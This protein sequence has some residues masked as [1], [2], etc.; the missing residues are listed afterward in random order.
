M[1]DIVWPPVLARALGVGVRPRNPDI[2]AETQRLFEEL[3]VPLLRFLSGIGVRAADGE[4]ILQEAF[5]AL[6][7]H[8]QE[9]RPRDNL[10]AWLYRVVHNLGLRHLQRRAVP[11]GDNLNEL[12]AQENWNPEA[13]T[14]WQQKAEILQGLI[15]ALPQTDRDILL[16][17]GQGLR[18]REI[19]EALEISLGTVAQSIARSLARLTRVLG[20][21]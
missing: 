11:H 9:G 7:Q 17:R 5:L 8:L 18:Y 6:F 13:A 16:L 21:L 19:A 1:S 2:E 3:R 14:L 12:A 20:K 10:R 4:D 15:R